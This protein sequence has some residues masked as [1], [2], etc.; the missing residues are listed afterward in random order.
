MTASMA[1]H[2][3]VPPVEQPLDRRTLRALM[4]TA[5]YY[6]RRVARTM[7]LSEVDREDVEQ[8]ILLALIERRR[9]FDPARGIWS[10]FADLVARQAAQ[11]IADRIGHER[12]LRGDAF[13]AADRNR[14]RVVSGDADNEVAADPIERAWLAAALVRFCAVLPSELVIVTALALRE[15]GDLAEAQRQSG[16]S[17]SE[18]Y[19]RLREI[20]YR[21]I[22]VGIV[23]RP[24]SFGVG[25]DSS[26]GQPHPRTSWEKQPLDRY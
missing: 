12:R 17:S 11:A 14:D 6:A 3:R 8:D 1:V 10:S 25:G 26:A 21:M 13:D 5:A 9:F 18:F 15:D 16:L 4:G 23:R 22:C 24:P 7:V 2:A 20:R 19:R